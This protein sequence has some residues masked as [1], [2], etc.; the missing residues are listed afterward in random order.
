MSIGFVWPKKKVSPPVNSQ[1]GLSPLRGELFSIEHLRLHAV[2]LA[3]TLLITPLRSTDG[4]FQQRFQ[5]T[6]RALRE[7]HDVIAQAVRSGSPLTPDAEWLLDNFHIVQEHLHEIQ[8]D[9][10]PGYFRELPKLADSSPRIF[11]IARELILHTDSV[12]QQDDLTAFVDEFQSIAP[13][14]IGELWALP[15]MLRVALVENLRC[16]AGQMVDSLANRAE[17]KQRL[18]SWEIGSRLPEI[19]RP[20]R[21]SPDLVANTFAVLRDLFLEDPNRSLALEHQLQERFPE[22]TESIRAEHRR[23]AADQVSIGNVITSMRLISALDWTSFF[24]ATSLAE[25][26]LRSDPARIYSQMDSE[27]RDRYRHAV[28]DL[29]KRS[30]KTDVLV[31]QSAINLA[32]ENRPTPLATHVGYWLIDD[33][34]PELERLL[35]YRPQPSQRLQRWILS[36]PEISYFGLIGGILAL[37]LAVAIKFSLETGLSWFAAIVLLMAALLPLSDFA[38]SLVNLLMTHLLPPR[39]LPKLEMKDGV[40]EDCRTFVVVPA[41]LTGSKEVLLL[42]DRLELHYVSNPE[43][44]LRFA[45]LTDFADSP[46]EHRDDDAA[47]VAQAVAG[48]RK[49]NE[50]YAPQGIRPFY[51]FHRSRRWNE[52]EGVWMGWERKRGKLMEFNQL[53]HGRQGTSFDVQ[54]G[55]LSVLQT[56]HEVPAFPFV[57]TLDADTQLPLGT[58]RRLIGAL[59]HPLNRPQFE[60]DEAC[61]RHGYTILQPRVGVKLGDG[62]KSWFTQLFAN[63][64]GI[65]PYAMAASDVYQDLFGEGSFT[66]KG[67]YDVQAFQQLLANAFGDNQILSHDLIEGCHARVALVSD[68]EVIDGY[69]ARYDADLRRTHRWVRGDW[70]IL[71]WLFSRVP[72]A[73]GHRSNRLSLLSRWKIFDNLRRSL[74][75]PMTCLFLVA[76]WFLA[77]SF[78][79]AWSL[80]AWLAVG[81]PILAELTNAALRLLNSQAF[82]SQLRATARDLQK[83][84]LQTA[85]LIACLP[86]KAY[87]FTDAVIRTLVRL[88]LTRRRM[89]EWETAAAA[90]RRLAKGRWSILWQM[91]WVPLGAT[92]VAALLPATARPA[93]GPWLVAW[94]F[95]PFIAHLISQPLARRAPELTPADKTWLRRIARDTWSYFETCVSERTNWLP[96]DN[97]QEYPEEKLAERVSPTNEG[98]YLV[99]GLVA[100]DFGYVGLHQLLG[101]WEKNLAVWSKLP[102]LHGHFYNWY[103]TATLEPLLPRYISTVDSGNLAAG[104]LVLRQGA[105][106]VCR[107]PV[108]GE[109]SWN[110]LRDTLNAAVQSCEALQPRGAHI[111]SAPLDDLTAAV[112]RLRNIVN[113]SPESWPERCAL[114]KQL[115]TARRDLPE[116]LA[117]F[118][119]S[120]RHPIADVETRIQSLVL[121]MEGWERDFAQLVPW[122][123]EYA[124]ASASLLDERLSDQQRQIWGN[125]RQTLERAQTLEQLVHLPSQMAAHT[126]ALS[127]SSW[128]VL[129]QQGAKNAAECLRRFQRFGRQAEQMALGMEFGF[130]FNS[131]R[132][133]F[134]IGFNLEEGKLDR[135]HYDMLCSEARLSSHLAIAKGDVSYKHWFQLGR[136]QTFTAGRQGLL[137]WGG[138]MFEFLMPI[139]FQRS[140]PQTLLADACGAAVARQE[141][142]GRQQG[143]PWGVSES[144]YS[145]LAINSDYQYQSFGVPGLGLKRGLSEDLVVA[146]YATMLALSFDPIA[147][148]TNLR[149]LSEEEALGRFGFYDA[150][151]YTPKRLPAGRQLLP[152]RCYMAHHQAMSLAAI[153]NVLFDQTIQRR[154]H[155][156]SLIRATEML[157]QEAMPAEAPVIQPHIEEINEVRTTRADAAIVS[158]RMI[159]FETPAPRTHLL[160]NGSY[161][162]MTTNTGGGYSRWG[163]IGVNRWRSDGL[164]DAGGQFFFIRD[165]QTGQVWSATYQPTCRQ[166]DHYEVIYAIDKAEY[167][168]RDDDLETHLE[169]V[170][171]PDCQMEVRQLKIANH[172]WRPRELEIT[173]YVDVTLVSPAADL[174][175]PAFQKLF[176]ETEYVAEETALV[177]RRRPRD[178]HT[179]PLWGVHVL[180]CPEALPGSVEFESSREIFLGR[181]Q[182]LREPAALAAGAHLSGTTGIVLDPVFSLRCRVSVGRQ[183]SASLAFSTGVAASRE[184]ALELADQFHEPRNVQRAFEMAW[185]FNQVQL[186]HLH[187]TAAQAQR[188]QQVAGLLLFPQRHT[189]GPEDSLRANRQ[190]QSGLWRFG[191]S[192]DHHLLLVKV[193]ETEHVDFVQELLLA[194]EYWRHHGL[195]VDLVIL[196]SHPG[197]YLDALQEQLQRLVQETPRIGTE[198]KNTVFLL[199][200]SQ[201]TREDQCLLETVAEVFIEARRGWSA[202]LTTPAVR[203]AGPLAGHLRRKTSANGHVEPTSTDSSRPLGP[204][205]AAPARIEQQTQASHSDT[206]E[207]WNGTGGFSPDGRE[208]HIQIRSGR[209]TPAPWS[210]VIANPRFG[211]LVTESGGGFTWAGNSRQNK[212]TSWSNDPVSDPPSEMLYLRDDATQTVWCPLGHPAQTSDG[213]WVHHGQGYTRFLRVRGDLSWETLISIAPDDPVKFVCVTLHNRGQIDRPLTAAYF[214]ELV[215]GVAREQTQLHL[216]SE[217]D[218][219]R[220]AILVRNRYHP[221]FAEQT[222]FL[223][224]IGRQCTATADRSEFLGRNQS[225]RNPAGLHQDGLSGACGAGLDPCAAVQSQFTLRGGQTAE[226]V[227]LLGCGADS[228]EAHR[229]LD[230][231]ATVD[232]VHAAVA[233]TM[234]RWDDLLSAVQVKTPNRAFDLLVNR[235]LLYQVTSCRLW[236][237]SAFYQ[238]GGA[239]GFRDQLQDVMALVYSRPDLAREHLLRAAARQYEAGDVQH[240]WH[241]PGGEGTRTRFSDDLLW[242]PFVTAHYVRVTG[243]TSVLDEVVPYLYSHPLA[244]DETERY[245]LPQISHEHGSLYEHCLRALERAFRVGDHGLPL[246]GC[247]DWNDGMNLVGAL[248]RGESVW[249]GWFLLVL[250]DNLLPICEARGDTAIVAR[251]RQQARDLRAAL[252][253]HGWDGEWYRRAYFDDGT[254]LGSQQNDE[255]RIDSIAQ[256]WAVLAQ[257]EPDRTDRA[258][259]AVFERLVSEQDQLV[260]LF[261]P[262]FDKTAVDPGYIKGYLPGVR[263]N[264]GQYTHA[265]YWLIQ[266]LTVKGDAERAMRLFDLINPVLHARRPD[267][268]G[269][270]RGEPYVIAADV[271]SV[272]PHTG[273]AG[274]T[275]YTGSASWAYRVAIE[276]ILGLKMVD[277]QIHFEPCVP[278]DWHQY[279]VAIRVGTEI[280][281]YRFQRRADQSFEVSVQVLPSSRPSNSRYEQATQL[282]RAPA[283]PEHSMH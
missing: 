55:D 177:A 201:M 87:V 45:L 94:F 3:K 23:Q 270:Y 78:A 5:Q 25:R 164:Q 258:L 234:K 126:A 102:Q 6:A 56:R 155:A 66:G 127:R 159:G 77:P 119:E 220:Q 27:S 47:L 233:L 31:A 141:E 278:A 44:E 239:Y 35:S 217:W 262:P 76:T 88:L 2:S 24:E 186:H 179:E 54:E 196:N 29:A 121:W 191:I 165:L 117:K 151:D 264:G 75:P 144:A 168:R 123:E 232:Q 169:I 176:V 112:V 281:H 192:G 193:A 187:I 89:L 236:G 10:P 8:D 243:D 130:L 219:N 79:A 48:I 37:S 42:L 122:A 240:W 231:Y 128:N 69:P 190:G 160:S 199:R 73:I 143:L 65:D 202:T 163:E 261:A 91:W 226:I 212:L 221:H 175:H 209:S 26:A 46:T 7:A 109:A 185:V 200:S 227:F 170:V 148:V 40:P 32:L 215:L 272:A 16:L 107:T 22:A 249:V 203:T 195:I 222:V 250:L 86:H 166:P 237:R 51:L 101:L 253:Q 18:M 172:G 93:A 41:L 265:A 224:A 116:K 248:G 115:H 95:S 92:I 246:M 189:R 68:I 256:S 273:R 283:Q 140:Y 158:R 208:Y 257:A 223:K 267:E 17:I 72:S 247:G 96:P 238:S 149:R 74:V 279:E 33:G 142:Y 153:A 39:I 157:L 181:N 49:L 80:V 136:Q 61:L 275:W 4:R 214:A 280:H 67:I 114:R 34:R 210:N 182:T 263:E 36:A 64:K 137:S 60:G 167:R 85:V 120:R 132:R 188:F 111:V 194:H 174:A 21:I 225:L 229:L 154:F 183:A 98:L 63:G 53:L 198:R 19:Y 197:S 184:Q 252:E 254:P 105:D 146:P 173:S 147:A 245:E 30:R 15:I 139:L 260:R 178:S 13:L 62:N 81:F 255:C 145:A 12:V 99:S 244:A 204:D 108:F 152:V 124:Q 269:R 84:S 241:P 282:L 259:N 71:P 180:A 276:C 274:W 218:D 230:R 213:G 1:P 118:V 43:S 156:H 206:L 134:A 106:D 207:F 138:T 100:R 271:Y 83:T 58:A 113:P 14:S 228:E 97:L 110:G 129:F 242:L 59:S 162:V 205:R 70:Q 150:V 52:A 131:Q 28:E 135:S 50:T 9:L 161:T 216:V 277:R 103:E 125:V 171:S 20:E 104:L 235:W 211:V 251:Y 266:A 38:V 82:F 268:T 90:E 11:H 57:V 133:L